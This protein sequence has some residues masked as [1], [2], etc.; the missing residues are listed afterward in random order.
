VAAS[1]QTD[2]AP[3]SFAGIDACRGGWLMVT[4]DGNDRWHVSVHAAVDAAWRRLTGAGRVLIDIPIG[5]PEREGRACDRL[6]RR[7]LGP[8]RS[9]VFSPPARAAL[10]QPDYASASS[11]NLAVLG[12]RL[13]KQ[14]WHLVP[15]IREVDVLLRRDP[16]ARRRLHESHPELCFWA[17]AG[18]RAAEHSKRTAAGLHERRRLIGLFAPA[19]NGPLDEALYRYPRRTAAPDD[20]LDAAALAVV[21]AGLVGPLHSIPSLPEHDAAHLPMQILF[22]AP[23]PR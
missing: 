17:M 9:S 16:L 6:A 14:A 5:L 15:R 23:A 22:P 19:S 7:L 20:V 2:A 21:A 1:R 12:K 13:S 4:T 3:S 8:R 10:A 11:T 18:G